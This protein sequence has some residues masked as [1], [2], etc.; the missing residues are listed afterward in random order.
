MRH[1][2]KAKHSSNPTPAAP[3]KRKFNRILS[4]NLSL[5]GRPLNLVQVL[6]HS[7]LLLLSAAGV[8]DGV[9]VCLL[10]LHAI[11]ANAEA[12]A[13]CTAET[14]NANLA[15][16]CEAVRGEEREVWTVWSGGG[17]TA[18]ISR[19]T[20]AQWFFSTISTILTD[21]RR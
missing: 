11:Q 18:R 16:P 2:Q 13:D 17:G 7:P 6:P 21:L 14:A 4:P 8:R 9:S 5:I 12:A 20:Q 3:F 19:C 15:L 1:A 10:S